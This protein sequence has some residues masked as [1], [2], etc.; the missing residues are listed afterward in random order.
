MVRSTKGGDGASRQTVRLSD[1]RRALRACGGRPLQSYMAASF[2]KTIQPR[3][4]REG[5]TAAFGSSPL[6][7]LT[8]PPSP[9][10]EACHTILRSLTLPYESCSLATPLKRWDYGCCAMCH[11]SLQVS[12]GKSAPPG[13]TLPQAAEGVHFPRAK[14]GCAVFP[15]PPGAVLK[16]LS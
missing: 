2:D 16:V 8:A 13:K 14:A 4:W 6:W 7:C 1:V 10:C 12:V 3:P 15:S 9:R 5:K 11:M